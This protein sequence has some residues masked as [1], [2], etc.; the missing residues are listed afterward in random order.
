MDV[1]SGEIFTCIAV[2]VFENW[3]EIFKI[4]ARIVRVRITCEKNDIQIQHFQIQRKICIDERITDDL[5]QAR[6]SLFNKSLSTNC[7][8]T[9]NIIFLNG[10]Y[11]FPHTLCSQIIISHYSTVPVTPIEVYHQPRCIINQGVSPIEVY[12]L[13]R[14]IT[15]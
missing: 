2:A 12:H 4:S 13:S 14:C 5:N 9:A 6:H 1:R 3:T 11:S 10:L 7:C 15:Y 8:S